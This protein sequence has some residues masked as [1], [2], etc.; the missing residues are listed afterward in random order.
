M[1]LLPRQRLVFY[2]LGFEPKKLSATIRSGN[3]KRVLPECR[4]D[5]SVACLRPRPLGKKRVRCSGEM[6][7]KMQAVIDAIR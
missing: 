7:Q 6:A 1:G 5:C 4:G 2:E 3:P